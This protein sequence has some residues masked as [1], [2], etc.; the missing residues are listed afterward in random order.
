M[1]YGKLSFVD[2]AG[3]ERVKDSKSEG[4]MLKETININKSLSVLGKV[5]K[6][7]ENCIGATMPTHGRISTASTAAKMA[8]CM[9]MPACCCPVHSPVFNA[10]CILLQHQTVFSVVMA[11]RSSLRWLSRALRAPQHTYP[12]GTQSSPSCLWTAWE[13]ARSRSWWHAVHHQ[14][15]RYSNW[16]YALHAS[17]NLRTSSSF[18]PPAHLLQVC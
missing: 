12:I 13:A 2:L 1:R 16:Q 6:M 3:S 9:H 7:A 17:F 14:A 5:R 18:D 10:C 11:C 4:T 8:P 15:C